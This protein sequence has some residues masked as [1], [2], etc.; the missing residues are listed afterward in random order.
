MD[1]VIVLNLLFDLVIF[2]L[3]LLVY[4]EKKNI[5]PLWVA[6]AF[7]LFAVSYAL[8]IV[9]IGNSLILIPL[10]A[11]GYLSVIVGLILQRKH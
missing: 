7:L 11:L 10:R 3:G 6:V 4:K 9:G 2:L 8:T 1:P 5:L